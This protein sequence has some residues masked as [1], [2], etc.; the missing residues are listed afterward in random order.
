MESLILTELAK[1]GGTQLTASWGAGSVGE[2][3]GP[4]IC[5]LG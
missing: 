3:Q 2:V 4:V 1:D 5:G